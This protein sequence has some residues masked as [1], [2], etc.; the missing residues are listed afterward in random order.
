MRIKRRSPGR[1]K[2]RINIVPSCAPAI[3]QSEKTE[4]H[5]RVWVRRHTRSE[6]GV[7]FIP[8]GVRKTNPII[9]FPVARTS[10]IGDELP[11]NGR[12][13]NSL[14]LLRRSSF[15]IHVYMYIES[16]VCIYTYKVSK[17]ICTKLKSRWSNI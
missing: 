3:S 8:Q 13:T 7:L 11:A 4:M 12:S 9:V 10:T 5:T 14:D 17:I 2:L 1:A 6:I 16:G 15:Y